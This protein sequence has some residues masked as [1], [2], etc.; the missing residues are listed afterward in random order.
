MHNP[1]I[2]MVVVDWIVKCGSIIPER[3]SPDTPLEATSKLGFDLVLEE[4]IEQ[5]LALL[6]RHS[7][8]THGMSDIHVQRS[9]PGFRMCPDYRVFS[10]DFGIRTISWIGFDSVFASAR[11]VGLR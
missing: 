1:P 9:S 5:R 10:H 7:R 2:T 4:I 6:L 3:Q 11:N 8:K